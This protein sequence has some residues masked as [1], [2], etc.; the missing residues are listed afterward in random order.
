MYK[1][2]S[3]KDL[4]GLKED[5]AKDLGKCCLAIWIDDTAGFGTFPLE[6][7]QC[8]T[9]IIVKRSLKCFQNIW[10]E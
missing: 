7:F 6:S 5:F 9:P 2:L 8:E 10:R 4:R 3:F 1:W